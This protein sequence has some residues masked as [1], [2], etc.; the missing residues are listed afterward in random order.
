[1][2]VKTPKKPKIPAPPKPDK[3][4]CKGLPP[5]AQMQ[6]RSGAWYVYFPYDYR[7]DGVRYQDRDYI[8][9]LN[10][11]NEFTPNLYYVQNQPTFKQ[12]PVERW[13]HPV[14]RQRALDKL[15]QQQETKALEP[16]ADLD[17]EEFDPDQQLSVGATALAAAILYKTGMMQDLWEV[18]DQNPKLV[19]GC[20]NLAMHAAITSDKTY[21]ASL[22]SQHQKFIG[23]GCLTS[24]RASEFFQQIGSSF[25]LSTKIAHARAAHLEPGQLCALDGTRIDCNSENIDA[26]AVGKRK[27]GTYGPQI[28]FSMLINV[29]TGAPICYRYYSGNT[30]DISTL[31]DFRALLADIGIA[32]KKATILMDR[33]YPS[34]EE[35]FKLDGQGLNFLVGAKVSINVV[36]N[37]IEERNSEFYDASAYL[38]RQRCYGLKDEVTIKHEGKEMQVH[39]YVFRSPNKEMT[40]TDEFL[41]SLEKF[42]KAWPKKK[43]LTKADEDKLKYFV[44]PKLGKPLVMDKEA[45]SYD[46]HALGYFG[47]VGNI[48]TTLLD[49]L[50]KYR[51]RNEVEV[52]FKL[53]FQSMLETT[54]V[55]SSPA[56]EGLLLTA[57]VGLSIP[58]YLRSHMTGRIENEKANDPDK[59]SIIKDLWTIQELLKDLRRI[60]LAYNKNGTVRLLNVV[61]RDRD[62]A[63]ALGFPGLF[64]SA[65]KVAELLTGKHL[66]NVLTKR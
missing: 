52:A 27:D 64:D 5:H 32:E 55:H 58:C 44:E 48:D 21:M 19:M 59:G 47:F 57:F 25:A 34:Y 45:V 43:T 36:K 15:K 14:M 37:I 35:F 65:E 23:K 56:L 13:K 60:K 1:M 31:D 63:D 39:S 6:W 22:E 50:D 38:R 33:G 20:A 46:C 61:K 10:E 16:G 41:D 11:N 2:P 29:D 66:V 12:R 42:A 17:P 9:K 3:A 54:R 62:L 7:I 24:P 26:K 51:R 18:F 8:G 28:N 40:E 49:A 30:A 53:M 4:A